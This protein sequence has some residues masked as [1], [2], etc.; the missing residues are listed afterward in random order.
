MLND[1]IL[2]WQFN[3][4]RGEAAHRIYERYKHDLVTLA[5]S[6]LTDL[7][8]AED[9]VHDVFIGFLGSAGRFRLTGSLKGYLC[10]CVANAARNRN[11]AEWRRRHE[12][13][14]SVNPRASEGGSPDARVGL[15]EEFL[16]VA[17]ALDQLPYEQ[18]EALALRVYGGLTF[19]AVAAQ[20]GVSV[21]TAQ[22]RFR[23]ALDKMRSLMG[24]PEP[25]DCEALSQDLGPVSREVTS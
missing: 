11:K 4:R 12:S 10:T 22:G 23:Y 3:R 13:L 21:S 18:R 5:A 7:S 1:R 24:Q 25:A 2:I 8:L 9:V 19:P 15:N 17:R 14:D 6:L 20:Q 16:R